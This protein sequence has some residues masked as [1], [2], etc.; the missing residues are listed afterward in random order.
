MAMLALFSVQGCTKNEVKCTDEAQCGNDNGRNT[1]TKAAAD[2]QLAKV[3]AEIKADVSGATSRYG[4]APEKTDGNRAVHIFLTVKNLGDHP[5]FISRATMK[6]ERSGY[7]EPCYAIGG[8]LLS[9]ATYSFTIPDDQPKRKGTLLHKTPFAISTEL[10]HEIPPNK[11]EKFT[12]TAGPKTIPDGGS[13][14]FGVL[15]VTLL[16]D[17]GEKLQIGPLAVVNTG[18]NPAFYPEFDRNAWHVEKEHFPG[19]MKKN[20]SLVSSIM[21]TPGLTPSAEFV[22]LDKALQ[23]Y[24]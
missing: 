2:L 19:C 12:L 8:D 20:V 16:R 21:R 17:T 18:A 6:F 24:K 1:D 5:A 10:T 13:P 4:E 23:A 7:L 3:T 15:D 22:A 9:T 11:Y 14:W